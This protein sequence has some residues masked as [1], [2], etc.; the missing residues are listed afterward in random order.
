MSQVPSISVALATY[1]GGKFLGEQL[2]S[3]AAQTQ[4]PHELIACDDGSTDDTLSILEAFAA[5]A[6][7]PVLVRRNARRLGY[8]DNFLGAM[9]LCKGDYIA[10]CDQD[11]LWLPQK[12]ARCQSELALHAPALLI[13]GATSFSNAAGFEESAVSPFLPIGAHAP[14]TLAALSWPQGMRMMVRRELFAQFDPAARPANFYTEDRRGPGMAHDEFMFQV[15]R[16]YTVCVIDDS[17]VRYRQH[18]ANLTGAPKD[19]ADTL[20]GLRQMTGASQYQ[21]RATYFSELAGF[22]AA[23]EAQTPQISAI[24]RDCEIKV[25]LF[26]SRARVHDRD[27]GRPSRALA[28]YG[29]LK[30]RMQHPGTA[31]DYS[32][33]SAAKD[34]VSLA[35]S[36]G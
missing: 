6:P 30:L 5:T 25:A 24:R 20:R 9:S 11:D 2:Q 27:A 14:L 34:V 18:P 19:D 1:N 32:L 4:A 26:S 15:L 10:C 36:R 16:G 35:S 22:F 28:L 13:H 8:A 33:R 17:L 7:F 3:I 12:I 21:H 23:C 31:T 29:L